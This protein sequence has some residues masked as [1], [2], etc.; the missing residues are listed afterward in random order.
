MTFKKDQRGLDGVISAEG[1]FI[2]IAGSIIIATIYSLLET[3]GFT[4][5]IIVL[6]GT[7]GNL[8]DSFLGAALERKGWIKNDMVNFLNTL[9]GALIAGALYSLI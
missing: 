1:L 2:G 6:A 4:F 3:W 9:T 8:T 5:F 7:I